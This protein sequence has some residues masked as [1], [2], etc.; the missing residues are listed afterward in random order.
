MNATTDEEKTT[1]LNF[2]GFLSEI[3][4]VFTV[5]SLLVELA[6]SCIALCLQEQLLLAIVIV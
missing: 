3:F 6:V 1:F 5:V 4:S 2:C